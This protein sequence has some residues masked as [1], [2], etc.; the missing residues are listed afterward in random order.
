MKI[1]NDSNLYEIIDDTTGEWVTYV[2]TTQGYDGTIITGVNEA[3]YIDNV[4]YIKLKNGAGYAKRSFSLM[5]ARWFGVNKSNTDC[6]AGIQAAV[7]MAYKLGGGIV[8]LPP[9]KLIVKGTITCYQNVSIAGQGF[10][11]A[12][13][14]H[15][16]LNTGTEI[17]HQ[18]TLANT[19]C[20][21]VKR[22]PVG[23]ASA[24]YADFS[25][26]DIKIVGDDLNSRDGIVLDTIR[27]TFINVMSTFFSGKAWRIKSAINLMLIRCR[28][29][30]SDYGFYFEPTGMVS[31]TVSLK[32]CYMSLNRV[33]AY[34]ANCNSTEFGNWCVFE[35]C[36][37][38]GLIAD[39]S[40]S[41]I[42]PYFENVTK[43]FI[44]AGANGVSVGFVD[45]LG[46]LYVGGGY[47]DETT[48]LIYLDDVDSARIQPL[49]CSIPKACL[50]RTTVNTG[51][52][53]WSG[54][55]FIQALSATARANSTAYAKGSKISAVC[56][57]G[58]SRLF[59]C[60]IAGTSAA[61][62]PTY[63]RNGVAILDGTATFTS[64]GQELIY[65]NAKFIKFS[66][67]D[68]PG[69]VE[70]K[71]FKT[72]FNDISWILQ[73]DYH[74]R[75]GDLM[76]IRS[77]ASDPILYAHPEND[78]VGLGNKKISSAQKILV[79]G[80]IEIIGT[81]MF[82]SGASVTGP[83][84]S[85]T[86]SITLAVGTTSPEGS[87]TANTGSYYFQSNGTVWYKNSGTGNTGWIKNKSA[88]QADSTATD[89]A[90]IVADFNSLLAKL[91]TGGIIEA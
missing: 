66:G 54:P 44:K 60:T 36:T 77:G 91:R 28:A 69:R 88:A 15:A 76:L 49:D 58:V 82:N 21:I 23:L 38:E 24:G 34:V 27:G 85:G 83:V 29:A 64:Y 57:D 72:S 63:T 56:D 46:G 55:K 10:D 5:D 16:T 26:R 14:T 62:S 12:V 70:A 61:T 1:Q 41:L 30:S 87:L 50:I 43:E 73:C 71:N 68:T 4:I 8:M 2:K 80:G 45:I 86:N 35:S 74:W 52:V 75:Q 79:D 33:C 17:N 51:G 84:V 48:D 90:G 13:T 78:R 67:R 19:D 18:P 31:T 40:V 9:E 53:I 6:T 20:F 42:N 65:N 3:T 22:D 39:S 81:L 37:E 32:A 11:S 25:M 89:I 7:D 47:N 59:I